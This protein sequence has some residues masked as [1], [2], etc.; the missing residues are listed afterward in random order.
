MAR[1]TID[2]LK[3]K[4]DGKMVVVAYNPSQTDWPKHL[5]NIPVKVV[6]IS[7]YGSS[8]WRVG[9]YR[10]DLQR[11]WYV[12]EEDVELFC[13]TSPIILYPLICKICKKPSRRIGK[14]Q[15]CSSNKCK[16]RKQFIK[17]YR[18]IKKVDK[19]IGKS[20]EPNS[21]N[22]PIKLLCKDCGSII[23]IIG[24]FSKCSQGHKNKYDLIIDKW[25]S[26]QPGYIK[27]GKRI[28]KYVGE[29]CFQ[30]GFDVYFSGV[31]NE[32]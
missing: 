9:V 11:T 14:T 24:T 4:F 5:E 29:G 25:Y 15:L 1:L 16:S 17:I 27:E 12:L 19:G 20:I 2:E 30:D 8:Q 3:E 21:P 13:P 28:T 22:N 18:N 26:Y 32:D 10:E 7:E 23:Q 6:S 31:K